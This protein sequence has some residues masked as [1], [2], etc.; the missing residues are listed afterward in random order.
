MMLSLSP[1]LVSQNNS[2]TKSANVPREKSF[3]GNVRF[4]RKPGSSMQVRPNMT[5][6]VMPGGMKE[7]TSSCT[8]MPS[9]PC[10]IQYRRY[11]S[12]SRIRFQGQ[13]N[14]LLGILRPPTR[15]LPLYRAACDVSSDRSNAIFAP[16]P[17]GGQLNELLFLYQSRHSVCARAII[18][19]E[20]VNFSRFTSL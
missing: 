16:A 7:C 15:H 9:I 2:S 13:R 19:F 1:S 6:S 18:L 11:G 12:N 10:V 3:R 20:S 17:P 14:R 4:S 5:R 8:P